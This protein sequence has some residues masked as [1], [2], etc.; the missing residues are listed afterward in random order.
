MEI[1]LSD[2]FTYKRLFRFVLPSIFMM[3]FTSVYGV[4]DGYFVSNFAGKIP[5]AAVN[6]IMPFPMILSSFSFMIGTGG[7]ALVSF[8]LGEGKEEKA[9]QYFSLFVYI[10]IGS[11]ILLT[12]LG[13][14]FMKKIAYYLGA[15]GDMLT[16]CVQYGKLLTLF[17]VPFMLQI[18][19]QSFL[20]AAEKPNLGLKMTIASGIANMLLDYIFIALLNG[21]VKGAAIATGVSQLIGGFIPLMFFARKNGTPLYLTKT[22][23]EF[24]AFAK[25]CFNGSSELMTNLSMSFVNMLYNI[26]LLKF[27]GENGVAAYGVIMYTNFVFV[28]IFLGYSI[29][30]APVIG[31][32][33]GS[34]NKKE[35]HNVFIKSIIFNLISGILM[36]ASALLLSSVLSQIFVGYDAELYSITKTAFII[37]SISYAFAGFNIYASSFFTALG[38]GIISAIISFLR[39]FLFQTIA[40]L[41]LPLIFGLD[42]IWFAIVAAEALSLIVSSIFIIKNKN[43]YGY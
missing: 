9:R 17:L 41:I 24:R 23:F 37:Y 26:Q 20:V 35:M 27:A 40:V 5:F 30:M 6:L 2:H 33:Y 7:T 12:I 3:V 8:A 10:T 29:G 14:I 16:Y 34:G 19:F 25:A 4:V 28:S 11:G 31:Y 18:L 21:G 13:I 38:N 32:N 39:T 22:R 42:G 15:R 36:F 1:K 43:K